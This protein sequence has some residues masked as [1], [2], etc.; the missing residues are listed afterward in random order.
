MRKN[1]LFTFALLLMAL[2]SSTKVWAEE[3]QGTAYVT[4]YTTDR[5]IHF[6]Y[7]PPGTTNTVP[8]YV[9]PT[10]EIKDHYDNTS[11]DLSRS[12]QWYQDG[13][14]RN[15]VKVIIEPSFA[16]YRPKS[17]ALWLQGYE[18]INSIEGLEY[19]NTSEVTDMNSM[20]AYCG[21]LENIDVS[22]FD[23]QNVEDMSSMFYSC[24]RLTSLN[25][26]GF[27][28]SNV[29]NM[30]NM[31]SGCNA[32][33]AIDVSGFDTQNVEDMSGMFSGCQKVQ[34]IDVGGFKTEKVTSMAYLFYGCYSIKEL[35]L[36]SFVTYNV[37]NMEDMFSGCSS[38]VTIY[39][40]RNAWNTNK[41]AN[42]YRLFRNCISIVGEKGTTYDYVATY[43]D[44][45]YA[46]IDGGPDNP[47]YLSE[48]PYQPGPAEPYA[49]FFDGILTFYYDNQKNQRSGTVYTEFRDKLDSSWGSAR[50]SITQV[51]FDNSFKNYHGVTSTFMWFRGCGYIKNIWNM[52]NLNTEN[53]TNMSQMFYGCNLLESADVS[54]FDTQNVN[55]M[56]YMFYDCQEL[57]TINVSGFNTSKVT[58]MKAM[59]YNCYSVSSLDVSGF[60]TSNVTDMSYMFTSC[61]GPS[62]LNVSS[63]ET[64]KVNNMRY[65]FYGCSNVQEI[66]VT[67]FDTKNVTDM[68]DLFSHCSSLQSVDVT[69]FDTKKVTDMCYMFYGCESLKDV[70]VT[71]FDTQNVTN[72][73]DLFSHCTRLE[74]VDL[75]HFITNKVTDMSFMF[76]GCNNLNAIDLTHFNTAEVKDMQYM[77]YDCRSLKKI[78]L[79]S[80]NTRYVECMDCMFSYCSD[81]T[82]IFTGNGWTNE[83][84]TN[85]YNTMFL[86]CHVLVG[87]AGTKYQDG[88]SSLNYA[89]VDGGSSNPGYFTYKEYNVATSIEELPSESISAQDETWYN[90]QGVRVD[91]PAKGI[92]IVNGKKVVRK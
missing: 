14:Y 24:K 82:T 88:K 41:I 2:C 60:D 74:H 45:M 28:T 91:N 80:F 6:Y 67:R 70:D 51:S 21:F 69:H 27:N 79:S 84:V 61:H 50:E 52:S 59:F 77:F 31:F 20:F 62:E 75:T 73:R 1:I 76:W 17:T 23:T 46:H 89:H 4:V 39:V 57:S 54:N 26:S 78:D 83:K 47:G 53:V 40:T 90:L 19:L 25:T 66:D 49:V 18:Y 65:M 32:L 86:D 72:I 64:G 43:S 3:G 7:C 9:G 8:S 38:V 33:E 10:Y 68:R 22:N 87:G 42:S 5:E 92:Y 11:P 48:S 30:K 29:K 81:V 35:D 34:S 13:S 63:F 56:S 55:N 58:N 71:H 85:V 15:V 12:P 16:D 37:S 44:K 36:K